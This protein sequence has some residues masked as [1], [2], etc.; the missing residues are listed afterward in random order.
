VF[1]DVLEESGNTN[2]IHVT[3]A[4]FTA[5]FLVPRFQYEVDEVLE[6][7]W[8]VAKSEEHNVQLKEPSVCFK[9]GLPLV[10]FSDANVIVALSDVEFAKDFHALEVFDVLL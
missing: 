1:V 3:F 6:G 10:F 5:P 9:S 2:V 7:G 4:F 8:R